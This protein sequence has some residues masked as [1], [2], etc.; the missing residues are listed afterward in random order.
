[1]WPHKKNGKNN[2]KK[3]KHLKFTGTTSM[4]KS[5]TRMFKDTMKGKRGNS[6][7]EFEIK[8]F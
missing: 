8:I 7:Q 2:T 4:T 3:N 6:W 5:R 1:M